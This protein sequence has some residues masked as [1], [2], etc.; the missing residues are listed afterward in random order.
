MMPLEVS[1]APQYSRRRRGAAEALLSGP[2]GNHHII[3]FYESE[4]S[5]PHRVARF[6]GAGLAEGGPVLIIA[7]KALRQALTA[8][9]N[10][11]MDGRR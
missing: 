5:L 1:P 6:L 8:I 10:T 3:Q 2:A 9:I 4:S 7:T 11:T